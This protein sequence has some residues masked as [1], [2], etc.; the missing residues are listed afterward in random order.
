MQRYLL[1]AR[2]WLSIYDLSAV[3]I[4]FAGPNFIIQRM[5]GCLDNSQM[6]ILQETLDASMKLSEKRPTM[7]S[8]EEL[9]EAFLAVKRLEGRSENTIRAL[10]YC[11]FEKPNVGK[12]TACCQ[13]S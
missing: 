5:A 10:S 4:R 13:Y 6:I 11:M 12:K 3:T 8:S 2:L 7:K 1:C 9:L